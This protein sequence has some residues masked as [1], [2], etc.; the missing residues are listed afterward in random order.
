MNVE[1]IKNKLKDLALERTTAFCYMC[2]KVCPSGI[3]KECGSDDLM[4]HLEGVGVEYGTDWAIKN[5]LEE[6]L[7]QVDLDDLFEQVIDDC[8]GEEVQIGFIKSDI[9]TAIK[10]LDPVAWDIAKS[11]HLDSLLEDESIIEVTGG[12]YWVSDLEDLL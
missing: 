8:Y 12:Y 11:E 5:I 7:T 3:C 6:K 10:A 9:S 1:E 2:Y 4:R